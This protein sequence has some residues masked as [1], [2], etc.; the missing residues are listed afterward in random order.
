MANATIRNSRNFSNKCLFFAVPLAISSA[1]TVG[2]SLAPLIAGLFQPNQ[3]VVDALQTL[4]AT[5]RSLIISNNVETALNVARATSCTKTIK[6]HI[7][8]SA[9][10]PHPHPESEYSIRE[11]F[12]FLP[13]K[14][15]YSLVSFYHFTFNLTKYMII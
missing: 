12:L 11:V 10:K 6:D 7:S 4:I 14:F 8:G 1:H 9:V 3:V 2:P 15:H 13:K 5:V